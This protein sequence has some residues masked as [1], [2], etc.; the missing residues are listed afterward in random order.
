MVM[1]IGRR[2]LSV[3]QGV[4]KHEWSTA[5][6]SVALRAVGFTAA[7]LVAGSLKS[8]VFGWD[9]RHFIEIARNGYPIGQSIEGSANLAFFPLWPALLALLT[10]LPVGP[11]LAVLLFGVVATLVNTVLLRRLLV[12]RIGEREATLLTLL[13]AALPPNWVYLSAYSENLFVFIELLLLYAMQKKSNRAVALCAL[14]MGLCRPQGLI[15]AAAAAWWI[16]RSNRSLLQRISA[17][18][19]ALAGSAFWQLAVSLATGVP[20][21]WFA[22]QALPAW[23]QGFGFAP[24]AAAF[25]AASDLVTGV[26]DRRAAMLV[27]LVGVLSLIGLL[28]KRR[29]VMAGTGPT[30]VSS[31][32][33]L[34]TAGGIGGIPRYI[35]GNPLIL[36][37]ATKY[38]VGS[39][40]RET[41][42]I[43]LLVAASVAFSIYNFSAGGSNP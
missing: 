13:W 30:I 15:W 18:C 39:K 17:A 9:G 3:P 29:S 23:G 43:L 42:A 11:V 24:F 16:L 21:A 34:F 22:I 2:L 28:F 14:L 20:L 1:A 40:L 35:S 38:L 31:L 26:I 27:V 4:T 32:L 10:Y 8:V 33:L 37:G 12:D 7:L 5:L 36:L 19:V 6:G 41:V 25:S